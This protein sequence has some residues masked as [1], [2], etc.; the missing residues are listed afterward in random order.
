MVMTVR[1]AGGTRRASCQ[2]DLSEAAALSLA[3]HVRVMVL[4]HFVAM[5]RPS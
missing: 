2:H 5:V 4:K 1:S 3:G